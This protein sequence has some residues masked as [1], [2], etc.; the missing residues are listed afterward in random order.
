MKAGVLHVQITRCCCL[1]CHPS[2]SHLQQAADNVFT[3]PPLEQLTTAEYAEKAFIKE[4]VK[5]G[6]MVQV[7]QLQQRHMRGTADECAT[8]YIACITYCCDCFATAQ[9]VRD[10]A[11]APVNQLHDLQT[12]AAAARACKLVDGSKFTG[13]RPGILETLEGSSTS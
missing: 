13:R 7:S 5:Y 9:A 11:L 2:L 4:V 6:E 1:L 3:Q 12:L 10:T 8:L